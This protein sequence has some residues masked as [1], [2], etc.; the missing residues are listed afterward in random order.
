MRRQRGRPHSNGRRGDGFNRNQNMASIGPEGR[1]ERGTAMQ[2][3]D[4]YIAHARDAVASGDRILAESYLQHAEHFIRTVN[5][6]AERNGDIRPSR[7]AAAPLR[8]GMGLD[9]LIDNESY[10]DE[11]EDQGDVA[12]ADQPALTAD[13]ADAYPAERVDTRHE[14]RHQPRPLPQPR[15]D[16]AQRPRGD[17]APRH[18]GQ[19]QDSQR[20]DGPYRDAAPRE[21]GNRADPRPDQSDRRAR[22]EE[23]RRQRMSQRPRAPQADGA[24]GPAEPAP[25]TRA[26]SRAEPRPEPRAEARAEPAPRAERQPRKSFPDDGAQPPLEAMPAFVRRPRTP[27]P[28]AD[29]TDKPAE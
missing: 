8:P 26:E 14:P 22:F 1:T 21:D 7:P 6:A 2:I 25:I 24:A 28:A 27:R 10:D 4:K 19:R 20:H 9:A 16:Y 5:A 12:D 23:Q 13:P 29:A 11:D 3:Y 15:N 18:D 17:F